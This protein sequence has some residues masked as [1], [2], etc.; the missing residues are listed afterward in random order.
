MLITRKIVNILYSDSHP[1]IEILAIVFIS[2][3]MSGCIPGPP[4]LQ[5]AQ[6]AA[7]P[8]GAQ[9]PQGPPGK[10][11]ALSLA[12]QQCQE[13]SYMIGFDEQGNIL[14]S[15]KPKPQQQVGSDCTDPPRL[16]PHANLQQCDLSRMNLSRVDL[17]HANLMLANL[18]GSDLRG[19]DLS[20]SN[21]SGA[22]FV[23]A[24]LQGAN[25]TV[26][27]AVKAHAGNDPTLAKGT[28]MSRAQLQNTNLEGAFLI[29]T[30]LTDVVWDHTRCPDGSLSDQNDEDDQTCRNNMVAM[31]LE[32]MDVPP[33]GKEGTVTNAFG[34]GVKASINCVTFNQNGSILQNTTMQE[35]IMEPHSTHA[36]SGSC[37][38]APPQTSKVA[39]QA[40]PLL[41]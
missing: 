4:G 3:L 35:I 7:G 13:G 28:D 19:A 36:W 17:N 34:I 1:Y 6:G 10:A 2:L 31:T 32:V 11:G 14:C 27:L 29:G 41:P 25:L 22:S 8:P 38:F 12:G 30:N 33:I 39:I 18:E 24:D 15:G 21:L 26:T 9:G 37:P 23:D 5:G 20:G 40:S 16:I